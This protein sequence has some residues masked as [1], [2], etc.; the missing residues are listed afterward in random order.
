MLFGILAIAPVEEN[1]QSEWNSLMRQ[2]KRARAT[3]RWK[4]KMAA[5]ETTFEIEREIYPSVDG[6]TAKLSLSP[7][8]ECN[9]R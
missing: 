9:L 1:G 6:W 8:P 3:S 5:C 4:V 2:V 7:D